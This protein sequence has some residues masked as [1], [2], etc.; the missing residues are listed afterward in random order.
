MPDAAFYGDGYDRF[1]LFGREARTIMAHCIYS[2]DEEVERIRQNGVWVAH[3]PNSNMNLS[4]GIAP[5]RKYLNLHLRV[6][7]GSDV[8]GGKTESIFRAVTDAIQ[9]SKL[10]WRYLDSSARPLSFSEAFYLATM[11]G[12]SFFGKVGC[13]DRG[14]EFDAVILDD[15]SDIHPQEMGVEERVERAFYLGLDTRGIIGKYA[16]GRKIAL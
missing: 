13:F 6:G 3:C 7:L 14:Y 10:Y 2:T 12:G 4:S 11:G 15:S 16:A 5:I 1:G 8:A 9:V